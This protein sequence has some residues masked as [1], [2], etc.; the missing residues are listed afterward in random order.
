VHIVIAAPVL[1]Y[2]G[3]PHAG[4]ELL[5]RHIGALMA[6][7]AVTL[8]V[9][10]KS[11]MPHDPSAMA[12]LPCPT[13]LIDVGEPAGGFR[14]LARFVQRVLLPLSL[15]YGFWAGVS[16]D[17]AARAA[18]RRADLIELQWFEMVITAAE[19]RRERESR[20][21]FGF[22]HDVASQKL[23]REFRSGKG[24]VRRLLRGVRWRLTRRLEHRTVE[25][26]TMNLCLSPKDADLLRARGADPE[27]LAVLDPPLDEP[28]MPTAP[29]DL[30]L[31]RPV[32]LFVA[33]FGR[34]ENDEAARWLLNQV[35]PA[36]RARR[37]EARLLLAGGG[38]SD[39]LLELVQRT[40]GVAA[41]G[42]LPSLSIAYQ[43]ARVALSP[44]RRGAGIKFKSI[45]PMLWG[46]PVIATRVGAEGVTPE[47]FL[48]IEDE[49]A[50]FAAALAAALTEPSAAEGL[51]RR[52]LV[53]TQRRYGG[54][55]YRK[56]IARIYGA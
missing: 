39:P 22:Y 32:A 1:P 51:R 24:L 31:R 34:V 46:V 14:R 11:I 28:D 19:L 23:E 36:V 12:S 21:I 35:W 41:T 43:R 33:A 8:L 2:P 18:L 53:E 48:A 45:I 38:M 52:A 29:P 16:R 10:R 49:P 5:L 54:A 20:P 3:V 9:P 4:G 37:P 44:V 7:H 13:Y 15:F 26:V 50:A 55:D 27:R 6:D 25:L 47:W 17:P 56:A 42:Y 30:R 40:P